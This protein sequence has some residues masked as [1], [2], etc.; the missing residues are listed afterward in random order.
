MCRSFKILIEFSQPSAYPCPPPFPST[1]LYQ[2]FT[3]IS[4]PFVSLTLS[5]PLL[6]F[7]LA[8]H[9]FGFNLGH[10]LPTYSVAFVLLDTTSCRPS[11][12]MFGLLRPSSDLRLYFHPRRSLLLSAPFL[13]LSGFRIETHSRFATPHGALSAICVVL[14]YL[15]LRQKDVTT[16]GASAAGVSPPVGRTRQPS[17]SPPTFPPS[18]L[19]LPPFPPFFPGSLHHECPSLPRHL[20]AGAVPLLQESAVLSG[21]VVSLRA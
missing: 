16:P 11:A 2:P 1:L 21:Q 13:R 9:P 17:C 20:Q 3:L 4:S 7:Q 19:P 12:F 5:F 14:S 6:P 15:P 8:S 10:V 18:P